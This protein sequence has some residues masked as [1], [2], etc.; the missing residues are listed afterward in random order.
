MNIYW[1]RKSG[2]VSA[3]EEDAFESELSENAEELGE[4]NLVESVDAAE[5]PEDVLD[6]RVTGAF[7]SS[8]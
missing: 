7:E 6:R 8:E 1:L 4:G 5:T 3:E 2:R